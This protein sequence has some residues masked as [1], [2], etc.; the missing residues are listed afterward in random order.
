MVHGTPG[1]KADI[2][3]VQRSLIIDTDPD[4][5]ILK[6]GISSANIRVT[7][8]RP[9]GVTGENLQMKSRQTFS[10]GLGDRNF[11]HKFLVC[12]LPTEAGGLL[13]TDFL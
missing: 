10:L 1:I 5:S 12:P 3:G 7:T 2:D 4:V 9:Y 6:P 11:D 13:G 8:L